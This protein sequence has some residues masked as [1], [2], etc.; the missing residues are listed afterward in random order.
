MGK[1]DKRLL[2]NHRFYSIS[3][4]VDGRALLFNW[5]AV[6][7]VSNND[8]MDAIRKIANYSK[9]DRPYLVLIDKRKLKSDVNFDHDWWRSEILPQ[10]H[11]A[12]FAGFAHIT[13]NPA[14]DGTFLNAPEGIRFK[15]GEFKD[16]ES[17]LKWEP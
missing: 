10:Y 2:E 13:G 16:I 4:T 1:S 6:S 3:L 17:A 15:M 8:Y 9:K 14:A 11:E 7:D 12:G 5:K